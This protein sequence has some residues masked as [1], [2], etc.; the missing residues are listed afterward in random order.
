MTS[1]FEKNHFTAIKTTVNL[2]RNLTAVTLSSL[3]MQDTANIQ[4]NW[5]T[6]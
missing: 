6:A 1:R 2:Q 4:H 5:A 3:C